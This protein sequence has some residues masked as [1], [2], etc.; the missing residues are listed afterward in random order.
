M[1]SCPDETPTLPGLLQ[2]IEELQRDLEGLQGE[3]QKH[4]SVQKQLAEKAKVL[5]AAG[6]TQRAGAII[7]EGWEGD[8]QSLGAQAGWAGHPNVLSSTMDPDGRR[9]IHGRVPC[10]GVG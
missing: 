4:E 6:D 2:H 7:P 5:L 9:K 8:Q 10:V 3:I 1:P